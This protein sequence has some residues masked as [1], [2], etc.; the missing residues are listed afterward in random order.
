M[1]KLDLIILQIDLGRQKETV[2]YL[3]HY[4]DFA[5]ANGYNAVLLYL[6]AA[7]KVPCVSFFSDEDTYTPEELREVV[8]YGKEKGIDIIPALENLAHIENFLRYEQL[9]F[10][11]ECRDAMV[12]GRGIVSGLGHCACV[13]SPEGTDFLATYYR[14]VISLFES[15][16]V[17]IGMDEP[18]DFAV[19]P[20]CAERL[21]Q[22]ETKAD[23]F[24]GHLMKTYALVREFGRTMM[25]W[26]D[27]FEYLDVVERLPRDILLCTWNYGF[28]GDEPQGHWINRKKKDWF[29]LYDQLGFQY[30]FCTFAHSSSKLYNT[31]TYT[32]YASK[33]HPKGALMTTWERN[34][35]LYLCSYPAIA[36]TGRLWSG[37]ATEADKLKIYTE[38]LG[39]EEAADIV[40]NLEAVGSSTYPNNIR[41]CENTTAATDCATR[42]LGYCLPRLWKISDA[43]DDCQAK[44]I[45]QDIYGFLLASYIARVKHNLCLEV[46]DNYESRSRSASY[47]AKKLLPLREMNRYAH[48]NALR[49][50]EKYRPGIKP[51]GGK[52]GDGTSK[53]DRQFTGREAGFD[54]LLAEVEKNEKRGVFYAELM[55]HCIYGTP[56]IILELHYKDKTIAPTV[57]KTGAK[58]SGAVNTVRFA[59][60]NKPLD[61]AVFTVYGEGAVYPVHF[62]YTCRGRKYVASGVQ[63]LSGEARDLKKLLVN[64]TQFAQLGNNDGQAHFENVALCR[65]KHS[66]KLKFKTMK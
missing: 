33:Y 45:L 39:S 19:C 66:I 44:D 58:V 40:L 24:Y 50:W 2:D 48:Q 30:L 12:D 5:K 9:A 3:K 53:L 47:F 62:R 25:M 10:L 37:K 46:F 11:S 18:F 65:V 55:L 41:I 22:G 26:D 51:S 28:I 17:H 52:F 56:K 31:D 60:E 29:R 34:T 61:Y 21:A 49:L 7:V 27:F 15:Q 4:I 54:A 6:E 59:M 1:K 8:A 16:Y 57:Y 32:N 38:F 20:R 43:M 14:Q 23:L 13:S 64:D 42:L 35:K 63:K 36:Y